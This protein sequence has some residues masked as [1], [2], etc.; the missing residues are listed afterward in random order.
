MN[1]IIDNTMYGI[2]SII[3]PLFTNDLHENPNDAR[4]SV[5]SDASTENIN[6]HQKENSFT[7][8]N[9]I[10]NNVTEYDIESGYQ[11]T[12]EKKSPSLRCNKYLFIIICIIL[13]CIIIFL[14]YIAVNHITNHITNKIA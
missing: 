4:A 6:E 11:N 9:E 12:L 7:N 8:D 5:A 10:N 13:L 3:N 1:N 2:R 14:I